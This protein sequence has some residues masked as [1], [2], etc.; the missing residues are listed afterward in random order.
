MSLQDLRSKTSR[1]KRSKRVGRG[2]GSGRGVFS[3]R[4]C[5]GQLARSGGHKHPGFEGGQTP[6]IRRMP[7]SKG[8]TNP[9][10]VEYQTLNVEDLNVFENDAVITAKEL[11]EKRLIGSVHRPIKLLGNGNLEKSLTIEVQKASKSAITKIESS[12]GKV[13]LLTKE[14][15]A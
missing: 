13:K 1:H 2:V 4:G 5:K 6:Y 10:Y 11:K 9:N 8:F 7:K 3:G 15:N 14:P 12:K